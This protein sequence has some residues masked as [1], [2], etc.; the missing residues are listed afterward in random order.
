MGKRNISGEGL[1]VVSPYGIH[2]C[3]C[4][5]DPRSTLSFTLLRSFDRV[6][7]QKG[8]KGAQIQ[9][10]LKY[11]YAIAPLHGKVAYSDLLRLMH[12]L[13]NT[14]IDFTKPSPIEETAAEKSYFEVDNKDVILSIFKCAEDGNGYILRLY[15]AS[16]NEIDV[17]LKFGI[18]IEQIFECNL[19]E[20]NIC[21]CASVNN[22]VE[23]RF[24]KWQIKT[25]RVL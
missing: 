9:G 5:D 12:N 20:E 10:V 13:A 24:S 18:H 7:R 16:D 15:N 25:F 8:A 4:N 21:E 6:R 23:T 11:K 1:A 3:S 22:F 2:E 17:K 14:D 19:N